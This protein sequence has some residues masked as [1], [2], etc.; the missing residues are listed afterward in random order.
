M[1]ISIISDIHLEF[2]E[3]NEFNHKSDADIT[4]ICGDI[5]GNA[6]SSL[7]WIKQNYK[8]Y[9]GVVLWVLGNHELYHHHTLETSASYIKQQIVNDK[10]LVEFVTLLDNDCIKLGGVTFVGSTLWTDFNKD[11]K[12]RQT[13]QKYMNDYKMIQSNV[14]NH[15]NGKIIPKDTQEKFYENRE[16]INKM[17][18]DK[19]DVVVITHHA[20]SYKSIHE[21]YEAHFLN[22]CFA[23]DMDSFIEN[24]PQIKLWC[25][26]HTH[27]NM[28]YEIGETR[29][30]CNP[31]GYY[32]QNENSEFNENLIIELGKD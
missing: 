8:D 5:C 11:D 23:S 15:N 30:I 3:L 24:N 27:C 19:K 29:I 18:S 13:A 28:D 7:N 21:K 25:H 26:G 14:H 12:D 17:I 10:E 32:N 9:T 22:S 6:D 16:Y 20:P 31:R 1:K 2:G 4:I